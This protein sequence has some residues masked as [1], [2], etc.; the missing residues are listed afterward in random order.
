MAQI[1]LVLEKQ[2]L[3]IQNREI[4]SSGDS[5]YDTCILTFDKS[6]EGFTKTAVFYQDK[7]YILC[8]QDNI[9]DVYD[10]KSQKIV[11]NIVLDNNGFYSKITMIPNQ[12]NA[13][14]TGIQTKK[15]LLLNLDKMMITKKQ[16]SNIDVANI[17]IIDTAALQNTQKE[18][19]KEAL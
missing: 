14:I 7:I 17:V 11:E 19:Q 9:V 5:N 15:F 2:L 13:L 1:R 12:P 16:N 18:P 6:W 4:I 8:A 10:T 3:T